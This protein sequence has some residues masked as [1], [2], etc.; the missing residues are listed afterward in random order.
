MRRCLGCMYSY[1]EEYMVCPKCGYIH[2][3]VPRYG[4]YIKPGV[5]LNNRYLVGKVI[6]NGGFGITYIG[7]DNSLNQ[8]IAIKEYFPR[9]FASRVEGQTHISIFS[10]ERSIQFN[11][12]KTKFIEEAQRLA[13]F[14][15]KKGIVHV[16]D[17]F[18]QN[19]T[20]YIIMEYVEGE[21]YKERLKRMG[22]IPYQE[23]LDVIIQVLDIL[24][25]VHSSGIIHR[26]IAPDNIMLTK[27]GDVVLLDFGASRF[28]ATE[29]SKSLSVIL[30]SGY[31][32]EEQYRSHGNQG[33]WTDVYAVSATFYKLVTGVTPQA[34]IERHAKDLLKPMSKMGV[35]VPKSVE[36]AIM[37]SLN[38][39][40]EDRT[41]NAK[42]FLD[43]LHADKVKRKR[44]KLLFTDIGRWP[45]WAKIII[46][47]MSI[48]VGIFISLI[49]SGV[50]H[51][52]LNETQVS[53]IP[54]GKTVVPNIINMD[55]TKAEEIISASNLNIKL[56]KKEYTDAL[57]ENLVLEQSVEPGNIIDENSVISVVI[58]AN[59][60]NRIV[61]D[62]LNLYTTDAVSI[63][64][65]EGISYDI[66]KVYCA[67]APETVMWQNIP[68]GVPAED[69]IKM[70]LI[71]SDGIPEIDESSQAK[72]P[73][74]TN[75]TL[76]EAMNIAEE[77]GLYIFIDDVEN[78][79]VPYDYI[80]SQD[81]IEGES[82]KQGAVITLQVNKGH[83]Y[84]TVPNIV[85]KKLSNVE[86]ELED[87]FFD[88]TIDYYYDGYSSN[89]EILYCYPDEG[90][91]VE[92]GSELYLA[93][94]KTSMPS[95][96]FLIG[97]A[98][99]DD[100]SYFSTTTTVPSV[101]GLDSDSAVN[102]LMDA[103][104]SIECYGDGIVT[105]QSISPGE[106]VEFG[107]NVVIYTDNWF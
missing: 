88:I 25:V 33:P 7:W 34:S 67:C 37:N 77:N 23:A 71:V 9:E 101:V 92:I 69:N 50:I 95:S 73:N 46:P 19:D 30:K 48:V 4:Y 39:R 29:Q 102:A 85:G 26:D 59:N 58:S 78:D 86:K 104:L 56:E 41:Q 68:G 53:K 2:N 38:I 76:G 60:A 17:Y 91:E 43:S 87:L 66:S 13:K 62:V 47:V 8:K 64:D 21:T 55:Y 98:L 22:K 81:I 44:E 93:V 83:G 65:V 49:A 54:E 100:S 40:I 90:E 96:D 11:S 84:V 42:D 75:M 97:P 32:P 35:K 106:S 10:G 80:V 99:Y 14:N 89:G 82:V 31:A 27:E 15:Q 63:L 24:D 20:A 45:L 28:A 6:G 57:S 18:E 1:N 103:G 107:T 70:S 94:N 52:N 105:S 72:V 51:F 12:G 3:S 79:S 36:N 74:F 5:I 61:P 16:Y